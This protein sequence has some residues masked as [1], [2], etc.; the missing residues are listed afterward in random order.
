MRTAGPTVSAETR[1]RRAGAVLPVNSFVPWPATSGKTRMRY[2][3]TRS[4]S[5]RA[6]T[7]LAL[8]ATMTSRLAFCWETASSR[9][10]VTSEEFPHAL[11]SATVRVATSFGTRF[12]AS[13]KSSARPGQMRENCCQV[14]RPSNSSPVSRMGPILNLSPATTSGPWR[15]AQPPFGLPA[16]PSGS[17]MTPSRVEKAMTMVRCMIC[18]WLRCSGWV[19][20]SHVPTGEPPG[21]HRGQG[22]ISGSSKRVNTCGSWYTV[23][24]TMAPRSMVKTWKVCS[25]YRSPCRL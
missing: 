9:S 22:K 8:P 18:S 2:S 12:I 3:S 6:W 7:T 4:A 14:L 19:T 5:A 15:N 1:R 21:T 24:R 16:L 17:S 25:R 13:E 11:T 20:G 10:P 23:V